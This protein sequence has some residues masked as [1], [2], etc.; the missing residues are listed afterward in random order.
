MHY[1]SSVVRHCLAW[2]Q[3]FPAS[4]HAGHP[5]PV[6]PVEDIVEDLRAG[7]MWILVDE[8]T[9]KTKATS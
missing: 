7:R 3:L 8:K 6:S 4:R 1:C 5:A 2:T 9:V